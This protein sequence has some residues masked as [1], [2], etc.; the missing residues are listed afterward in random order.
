MVSVISVVREEPGPQPVVR[1]GA[2]CVWRVSETRTAGRRVAGVTGRVQAVELEEPGFSTGRVPAANG[3]L[4]GELDGWI[5]LLTA[6]RRRAARRPTLNTKRKY[7]YQIRLY[8]RS[9]T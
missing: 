2:G 8:A 9:I 1:D 7:Q 3:A 4:Q 6:S 5:H